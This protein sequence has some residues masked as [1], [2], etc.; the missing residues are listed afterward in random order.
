MPEKEVRCIQ[1]RRGTVHL[2][3]FFPVTTFGD[4]YPLDRLIQPYLPRLASAILVSHYYAAHLDQ[5]PNERPDLPLFI[6]SGGFALLLEGSEMVSV[7][8]GSWGIRVGSDDVI[9][10]VGVLE[11][12]MA[13]AE[14]GATLDF[15]IPPALEDPA[16]RTRRFSATLHNAEWALG[17][18]RR[19]DLA[20]F[21][22]LQCWDADSAAEAA[23]AI[24]AM[25]FHGREFD[26]I[27]I[28]GM[29]PRLKNPTYV[30][31]VIEAV[32]A[33]WSGPNASSVRRRLFVSPLACP[34]PD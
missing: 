28:G 31:S 6:D 17:N 8:G 1:T 18:C 33:Q 2:P 16:E 20:L 14:I 23:R 4:T 25:R 10:P 5:A 12:H 32:R 24:A 13:H 7:G 21:A 19:R 27:A 30:Q 15:P 9:S 29:V 11:R 22:S 3:T 26:G 34:A